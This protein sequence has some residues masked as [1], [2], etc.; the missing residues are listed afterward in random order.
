VE[1]QYNKAGL[2]DGPDGEAQRINDT[3]LSD[4]SDLIAKFIAEARQSDKFKGKEVRSNYT[5]PKEYKGPHP[6]ADQ[7]AALATALGLDPAS[8]LEYATHLPELE[9]FVPADALKWTGW[10][11]VPS[12]AA[13]TTLAEKNFP[14]VEDMA[15]RYCRA[16]LFVFGKLAASRPFQNWREGQITPEQLR[17][18]AR[19]LRAMEI[20]AETQKGDILVIAAQLGMRH[21]G[22]ATGLAREVFVANEVGLGSLM[23]SSIALTHP[24]RFVRWEELDMDLPGDEFSPDADGRFVG[25]PLWLVGDGELGF[26]AGVVGDADGNYGSGSFFLPQ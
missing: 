16:I 21:R 22:R 24:E 12:L 6:I 2:S 17:M 19:L 13:L 1:A 23:G 8:A 5:Y 11:A 20:L 4:L 3:A 7:I 15:E 25:A 26:G 10:F 14:D 18:A 9:S